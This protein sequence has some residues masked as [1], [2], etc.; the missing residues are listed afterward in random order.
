MMDL[1]SENQ[2]EESVKQCTN[3]PYCEAQPRASRDAATEC[4]CGVTET[5]AFQS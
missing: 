5:G 2:H 1:M 4:H 3:T